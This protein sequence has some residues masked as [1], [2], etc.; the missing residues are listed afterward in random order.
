VTLSAGRLRREFPALLPRPGRPAP[1][2]LDSACMSL[3]PRCV[4]DAMEEYYREFPGCAGRSLHRFAEEVGRRY[5]AARETFHRFL[6]AWGPESIV[7]LRNATEA[8]NLVGRGLDWQRDDRVLVTDREHNSNLVP[9]QRL[10]SE[11]GIRLETLPL[12]DDGAWDSDAL[13]DR[14]ASGGVRLAS[15]FHVSNLDGRELPVREIA[16]R[17]HDRGGELLVDGCQAAPHAP[18]DLARLGVDYYA[19]SAHKMLGPT[20]TG[21]LAARP[22]ALARLAPLQVGGETVE[23]TTWEEHRLRAPPHRFEAGLQNYA[24]VLG[25]AR[26][27][28]RLRE[29]GL[30]EV[31]RHERE[32]NRRTTRALADERR[33]RVLGPTDPDARSGVFAFAVD[34][35]DPHDA[36][37][38][39]DEGH[40]VLVRSGMHCVHSWYAARGLTGNVR[41]SFYLYNT[42][43]DA[44]AFVRGVREL[45]ERVPASGSG[46]RPV[47]DSNAVRPS[48]A[49]ELPR[50]P[51]ERTTAISGTSASAGARVAPRAPCRARAAGWRAAA[52]RSVRPR[53]RAERGRAGSEAESR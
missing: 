49:N 51:D 3:V 2:Y 52:A 38:F 9:W 41:A 47:S 30:E 18:V 29:V 11:R 26:G 14:L 34:G 1:I 22:E 4:L 46:P 32:L 16:E 20:G 24:G 10:A 45:L 13:E 23:W 42:E 17:V 53:G 35:I 37:L 21:A 19:V 25:A 6:G 31:E 48:L 28:E 36:A 44:D 15:V 8:I 7:F 40:R 33:V 12:S 43:R 39:L 5:E 50:E 27:L